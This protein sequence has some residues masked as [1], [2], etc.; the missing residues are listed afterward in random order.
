M[1]ISVISKTTPYPVSAGQEG[2]YRQTLTCAWSTT[3]T[4]GTIPVGL[5]KVLRYTGFTIL[6]ASAIANDVVAFAGT[7]N[8]DGSLLLGAGNVISLMRPAGTTSACKF[9]VTFEGYP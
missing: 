5:G 7:V 3:D 4:T 1:A 2:F 6:N 8:A 9:T